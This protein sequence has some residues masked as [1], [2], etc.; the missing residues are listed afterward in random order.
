[1]V[2]AILLATMIA[3][4]G[5]S[6]SRSAPDRFVATIS[7][8]GKSLRA[9][10]DRRLAGG[11]AARS[12]LRDLRVV[13]ARHWGFDGRARTGRLIVHRDVAADVV[14][15]LRRLLRRALPD[16]ADASV[17]AYGGERLPLDRGRQHLG[18]QL[19]VVD[20]HD[21]LVGA[22]LRP[23]DRRQPDREPVRHAAGR[24]R[25]ARA[26]PTSTASPCR[27]GMAVEGGVVVRA[28]DA[29]GWGWGGRWAG[30]KDYQHFS[31]SGR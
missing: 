15:V 1:M 3:A 16:P 18:V 29:V 9:T 14:A 30:V 31:A 4:G 27:P 24:R 12:L 7:P 6:A 28:F 17:D 11:P 21:A 22:R 26:C 5:A 25:T 2:V 19:P 13:T 10:D 8:I 23:R 20:G